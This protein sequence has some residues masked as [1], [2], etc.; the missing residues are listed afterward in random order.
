MRVEGG[1]SLDAH[2]ITMQLA[3]RA[4]PI[5]NM[6][7]VKNFCSRGKTSEVGGIWSEMIIMKTA[8][9]SK[10]VMT[11]PTRS[12]ESGGRLNDK[13]AKKDIN[14]LGTIVFIR[15]NRARLLRCSVYVSS[16]YGSKQQSYLVTV[17]TT[18]KPRLEKFHIR[19]C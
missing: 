13:N 12:P 10:V 5:S 3:I 18:L 17:R 11:S 8:R 14:V 15:K 9:E 1:P 4:I 19:I 16:G 7:A 2:E 6:T